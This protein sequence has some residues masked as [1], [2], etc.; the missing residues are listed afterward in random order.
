MKLNGVGRVLPERLLGPGMAREK[1][2]ID[3]VAFGSVHDQRREVGMVS[4]ELGR[5][6]SVGVI[7]DLHLLGPCSALA[8]VVNLE[9]EAKVSC[10]AD[11]ARVLGQD[12]MAPN[13]VFARTG[14]RLHV[15]LGLDGS[16]HGVLVN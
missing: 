3:S 16:E 10:D 15:R 8:K 5:G 12:G 6:P 4:I 11:E 9:S 13:K 2:A 1:E 14:L 7:N